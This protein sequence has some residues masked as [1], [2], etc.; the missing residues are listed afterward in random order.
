MLDLPLIRKARRVRRRRTHR[1]QRIHE[2][3]PPH[4]GTMRCD[5]IVETRVLQRAARVHAE[6][7]HH[8]LHASR[9]L[10]REGRP[11][12]GDAQVGARAV[13]EKL[14]EYAMPARS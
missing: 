1:T 4:F 8:G 13:L 11:V 7:A 10:Q 2:P 14:G 12:D 9:L 3:R 5:I 6:R